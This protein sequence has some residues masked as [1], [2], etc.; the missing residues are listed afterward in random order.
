[1]IL[2]PSRV[3]NE[4]GGVLCPGQCGVRCLSSSS[5]LQFYEVWA[6]LYDRKDV[7]GITPVES[8]AAWTGPRKKKRFPGD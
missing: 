1:M 6:A 7:P 2:K 3:S 4:D 5:S 8:R